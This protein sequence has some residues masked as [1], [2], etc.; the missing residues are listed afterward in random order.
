MAKV[1]IIED[2]LAYRKV[3]THKFEAAGFTVE[4]AEN[5]AVGI[6]KARS[7]RPDI[8][9]TDLMM[10]QMDGFQVLDTIKGDAELKD[11]PVVVLTNLSTSED[12]QKVM[13]K[14]AEGLLVKSDTEPQVIVEKAT[15]V[16]AAH[17]K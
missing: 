15:E 14:G 13:G 3:Y 5:G 2:D 9:L 4:A 1:L 12:A 11:I 6:E 7:F 8:I 10:P 16:I 17:Q